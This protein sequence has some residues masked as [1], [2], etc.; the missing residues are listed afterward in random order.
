[1]TPVKRQLAGI[2]LLLLA[3]TGD[4]SKV[5]YASMHKLGKEK[6]DI[7]VQRIKDGKKDQDA[8]KEQLKTILQ[9][10]QELT[11]F[12]GGNLERSTAS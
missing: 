12:K 5:Y 8:A 2:C 7:L 1:M 3:A 11:G 4:C 10:F 9:D 6:R